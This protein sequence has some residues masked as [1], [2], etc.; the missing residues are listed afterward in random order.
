MMHFKNDDV[1]LGYAFKCVPVFFVVFFTTVPKDVHRLLVVH[2]AFQLHHSRI[3]VC[4][5]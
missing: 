2:G 1:K 4:D 3:H 5:G